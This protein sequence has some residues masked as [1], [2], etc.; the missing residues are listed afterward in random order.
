MAKLFYSQGA[1][2]P[3]GMVTADETVIASFLASRQL[4]FAQWQAPHAISAADTPETILAAYDT[5]LS[6][7]MAK[8]GYQQADVV[9]IHPDLPGLP[10]M[11]AKFI[12]E[13]THA[14]DEVRFFVAGHGDFWFHLNPEDTSTA[15]IFCLTCEAGELISVPAGTTHWFDSGY[16]DGQ[17]LSAMPSVTVIRIFTSTQG[18]TPDYTHSGVSTAHVANKQHVLSA[19]ACALA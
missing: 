12:E 2:Y 10:A 4:T 18:W 9:H 13:H 7:Y 11:H 6:P 5:E 1:A 8:H 17:T 16:R 15:E 3:V 14:E 19:A